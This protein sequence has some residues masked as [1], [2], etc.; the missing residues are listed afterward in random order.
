MRGQL[1]R[2][3]GI[4]GYSYLVAREDI[5]G[6]GRGYMPRPTDQRHTFSAY[7]EDRMRVNWKWLEASRLHLRLLGG[8]GFPFTPRLK[9]P[10][11][12]YFDL[13]TLQEARDRLKSH[14]EKAV[15]TLPAADHTA[16]FKARLKTLGADGDMIFI[17]LDPAQMP[18]NTPQP[19]VFDFDLLD[20]EASADMESTPLQ[21]LCFTVFDTETTGLS[22]ADDAIVQIAAVR[23]LNARLVEGEAFDLLVNPGRAIPAASTR[24]HGVSDADVAGAADIAEVGRA[25]HQFAEGAVLVAHNA[26]FDIGLLRQQEQRIGHR[27]ADLAAKRSAQG[28]EPL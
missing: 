22:V 21:D 17:D 3:T 9:A 1:G 18:R 16:T 25:F 26:P 14:P 7:I 12:T 27:V 13:A 28:Q 10:L 4:A 2:V 20:T 11:A 8:S 15:F 6:D 24:I 19:L 23:I 5:E